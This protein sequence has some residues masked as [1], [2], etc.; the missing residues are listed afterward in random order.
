MKFKITSASD[1]Y[2]NEKQPCGGAVLEREWR[3]A[4]VS[5]AGIL[6]EWSVDVTSVEHL[7]EIVRECGHKVIISEFDWY[8]SKTDGLPVLTIY[9]EWV[10]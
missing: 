4:K 3:D 5:A 7:M 9:D 10:E 1:V 6:R 2:F 8:F